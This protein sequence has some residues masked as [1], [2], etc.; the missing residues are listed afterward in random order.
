MKKQQDVMSGP[1]GW[2][3][4]VVLGCA[5]FMGAVLISNFVNSWDQ[6]EYQMINSLMKQNPTK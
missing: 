4:Y 1:W 6:K 2:V 5:L 3:L